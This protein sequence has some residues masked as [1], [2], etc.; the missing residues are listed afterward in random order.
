MDRDAAQLGA[1]DAVHPR[2]R[3]ACISVL[4]ATAALL[5][6]LLRLLGVASAPEA[7]AA[8]AAQAARAAACRRY[9]ALEVRT[10]AA[11]AASETCLTARPLLPRLRWCRVSRRT[12]PPG[13]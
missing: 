8:T 3:L 7:A 12:V 9:C 13:I 5:L 10:A 2:W 4:C 6:L 1:A 11:A